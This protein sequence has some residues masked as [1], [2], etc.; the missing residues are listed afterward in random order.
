MNMTQQRPD[1]VVLGVP[2]ADGKVAVL[3]SKDLNEAELSREVDYVHDFWGGA[4]IRALPARNTLT[5]E[6]RTYTVVVADSYAE[7]FRTLFDTWSPDAD[8]QEITA[9]HREIEP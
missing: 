3:A 5:V 1:W 7:A 8:R 2:A 4:R 6:M 9:G